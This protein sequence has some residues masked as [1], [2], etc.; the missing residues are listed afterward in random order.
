VKA[1]IKSYKI[2]YSHAQ[3]DNII[4]VMGPKLWD[5]K[6]ASILGNNFGTFENGNSIL[7]PCD[8]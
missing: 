3:F 7:V 4:K 6:G 5:N 2:L 8:K 1:F